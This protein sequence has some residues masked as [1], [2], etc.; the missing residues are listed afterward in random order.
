MAMIEDRSSLATIHYIKGIKEETVCR[1]LEQAKS[2]I[3]QFEEYIVREHKLSYVQLDALW[4]YVGHKGKKEKNR[5]GRKRHFLA[6]NSNRHEENVLYSSLSTTQIA[7][8]QLNAH[9]LKTKSTRSEKDGYAAY[10]LSLKGVVVGEGD[11]SM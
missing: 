11:T 10:P 2:H 6:W 8:T 7:H 3:E 1:W 9:S 5:K 4:T